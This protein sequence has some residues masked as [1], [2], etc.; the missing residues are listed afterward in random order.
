MIKMFS[1]CEVNGHKRRPSFFPKDAI[2]VNMGILVHFKL[3][4]LK[5]LRL[6]SSLKINEKALWL[7][8]LETEGFQSRAEVKATCRHGSMEE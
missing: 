6:S 5:Y 4:F 7:I 3:F 8:I 2:K 1:F